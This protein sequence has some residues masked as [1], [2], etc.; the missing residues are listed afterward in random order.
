MMRT[1]FSLAV[2]LALSPFRPVLACDSPSGCVS[3][4]SCLADSKSET[5][6]GAIDGKNQQFW[7]SRVANVSSPLCVFRN[8]VPLVNGIDYQVV[9]N[10]VTLSQVQTPVPGDVLQVIY[11]P[12]SETPVSRLKIPVAHGTGAANEITMQAARRALEEE[13]SQGSTDSRS[14]PQIESLKMLSSQVKVPAGKRQH[15][16]SSKRI[17]MDAQG[18]EGLGD[19]P[20]DT[21]FDG[22]GLE[23]LEALS[24]RLKL[25]PTR[26]GE[27]TQSDS[28]PSSSAIDMLEQR[29]LSD[30][31]P[32]P[33]QA[34]KARDH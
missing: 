8:G 34:E 2:M 11:F 20:V 3:N 26:S 21:D 9:R 6:E 28:G 14:S 4:N 30:E 32:S 27:R 25:S 5:P 19:S 7:I 12:R 33:K 10:R 29:I 24:R 31:R 18:V 16:E 17:R 23:S 1:R 15:S 22:M 13:I